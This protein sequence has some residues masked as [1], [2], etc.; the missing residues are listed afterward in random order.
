MDEGLQTTGA[1]MQEAMR[2]LLHHHVRA[3]SPP[4]EDADLTRA[5][6]ATL[7]QIGK[8]GPLSMGSLSEA[9]TIS[10]GSLTGVVDRLIEKGFV[11]RERGRTD[12]RRV[13]VRLTEEGEKAYARHRESAARFSEA[14]MALLTPEE[15]KTLL[16]LIQKLVDG[17]EGA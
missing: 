1:Q 14:L 13:V 2:R 7:V 11:R 6:A 16:R 10:P 4:E 8:D 5:Q 15:G 3:L 9:L 12:R 17:L